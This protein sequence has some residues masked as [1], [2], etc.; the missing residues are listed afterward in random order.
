MVCPHLWIM[1]AQ[2][3]IIAECLYTPFVSWHDDCL[4]PYSLLGKVL[5]HHLLSKPEIL[6][7]LF[8]KLAI[9]FH[10]IIRSFLPEDLHIKA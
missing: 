9:P 4:P 1:K 3:L 10:F 2:T 8:L 6:Q 5:Q 7:L